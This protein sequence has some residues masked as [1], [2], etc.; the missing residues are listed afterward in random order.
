Q[1]DVDHTMFMKWRVSWDNYAKATKIIDF[2]REEQLAQFKSFCAPELLS[3]MRHSMEIPDETRDD[4]KNV[5]D[6][7]QR[8]LLEGRNIAVDRMTF[9]KVRQAEGES[10]DDF[11]TRLCERAEEADIR[12]IDYNSLM[13]TMVLVGVNDGETRQ[14]LMANTPAPTLRETLKICRSEEKGRLGRESLQGE[15]SVG[16]LRKSQ[17]QKRKV[18]ERSQSSTRGGASGDP[19]SRCGWTHRDGQD[20]P[21]K[22]KECRRC[23]KV[24]HFDKVCW[25]KSDKSK[26]NKDGGKKA[27]DKDNEQTVPRKQNA[28]RIAASFGEDEETVPITIYNK[29]G[30]FLACKEAV[31][32]TGAGGTVA[33]VGILKDFDLEVKQL[34]P[35]PP[36]VGIGETDLEP[37]GALPVTLHVD[38]QET[39]DTLIICKKVPGLYLSKAVCKGLRIIPKASRGPCQQRW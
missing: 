20:C 6:R 13:A 14:R 19:C 29:K 11:Y 5:L 22:D 25:L 33:N 8:F 28:I 30:E 23:K 15:V 27:S 10:F 18:Q 1:G 35:P 31:A 34:D 26:G 39:K 37:V 16:A 4:L 38:G 7:I 9:I 2:P 24:G 12:N 17:Y 32:D 3:K 36:V 21:A